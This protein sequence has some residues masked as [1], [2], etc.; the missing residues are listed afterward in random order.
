MDLQDFVKETL[1]Q[2]A[3]GVQ[4]AQAEVRASGG[5]VNPAIQATSQNITNVVPGVDGQNVYFV[6]FDV[7]V[8]VK[9]Q[10]G[11]DGRAKLKVASFLSAGLGAELTTSNASTNRLTFKIPLA[12]PV[13][14]KSQDQFRAEVDA[15][16]ARSRKF[17]ANQRGEF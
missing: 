11:T 14:Q 2:I 16:A 10:S 7:A 5:I 3:S 4:A 13:D 15:A 1:V 6:D 12:F 9:D 8:T 17:S